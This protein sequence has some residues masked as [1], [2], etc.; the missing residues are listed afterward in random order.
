[1]PLTIAKPKDYQYFP[2]TAK[3][4]EAIREGKYNE[5]KGRCQKCK[6]SVI[7]EC[8]FWASAHLSH[9]KSKG[10]GGDWSDANLEILCI[11]CH[12]IATHNPKPCPK[13]VRSL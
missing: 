4:K 2:K 9:K 6:R 10:A 8:G 13:K 12:L 3:E 11:N 5:A 7:L 1:M